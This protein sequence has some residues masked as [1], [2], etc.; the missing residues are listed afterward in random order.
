MR[1]G[2][3]RSGSINKLEL[4]SSTFMLISTPQFQNVGP[5]SKIKRLQWVKPRT[6]SLD[7]HRLL[8]AVRLEIPLQS[9]GRDPAIPHLRTLSSPGALESDS[10]R[11]TA[12]P[13]SSLTCAALEIKAE[14][15][16]RGRDFRWSR[17]FKTLTLIGSSLD[18]SRCRSAGF[19]GGEF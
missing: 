3:T 19:F 11:C 4:Q 13:P 12:L 6:P 8:T 9:D 10:Y 5:L 1:Q 15:S 14:R 17:S 18:R 2:F 7:S 16:R